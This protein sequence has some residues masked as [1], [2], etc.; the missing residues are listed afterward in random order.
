MTDLTGLR[1]GQGDSP[2][3]PFMHVTDFSHPITR[4][5]PQDWFWGTTN[6]IGPLFHLEDPDATILGQVVYSLGRC[7]PGFG[8]RTFN[9]QDPRAAWSSIYVATPDIPAPVLRGI[10]RFAGVHLYNEAGDVLYATPD[11]LGV[12]SVSGGPRTFQLPRPV[13][14]VYDLFDE[15]LLCRNA[16]QFSVDLPPASTALYFTGNLSALPQRR[17]SS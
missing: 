12:H 13:E 2:W 6:P 17:T 11:L 9:S 7:K 5:L 10:A 1:F 16:N 3:G 14:V 4:G 15:R 8:V